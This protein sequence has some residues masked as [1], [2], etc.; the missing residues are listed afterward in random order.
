MNLRTLVLLTASLLV[1]TAPVVSLAEGEQI[2]SEA[3]YNYSY[4]IGFLR[5]ML[6]AHQPIP[7]LGDTD[8]PSYIRNGASVKEAF[9]DGWSDG[10]SM[11]REKIEKERAKKSAAQETESDA[12][13]QSR[14]DDDGSGGS[15]ST[16]RGNEGA[17][18]AP[19]Y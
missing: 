10:W 13:C 9:E 17:E 1:S 5:G 7:D 15:S 18:G 4:D 12:V 3:Q 6:D 11:E 16:L 8:T 14:I 19:A 2:Y